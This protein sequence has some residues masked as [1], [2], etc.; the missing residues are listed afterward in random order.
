MKSVVVGGTAGIGREI[1]V[2]LAAMGHSL[3]ITGKDVQDVDACTAN[4]RLLY[5]IDVYGL[6]IQASD[7]P[8][9]SAALEKAAVSFGA[10]NFLFLPIGASIKKDNGNL[11]IQDLTEILNS[12]LYSVIMSVQVFRSQFI[13]EGSAGVIGFSSVA[14]IRGRKENVFY[15]ASKRALESYFESLKI[16]LYGS[17]ISVKFYRLGYVDTYQSYG[18]QL[19]FSKKD[20]K[21]AAKK[22]VNNLNR[23]RLVSYFPN[24]WRVVELLIRITPNKLYRRI[25]S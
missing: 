25:T 1:A 4:L 24:Y 21:K 3:L 6:A 7:H 13:K 18:K 19:I 11:T 20:P 12:N 15:S 8:S 5:G 23:T 2:A 22:I 14:A 10:I 9:F 17:N 16:I